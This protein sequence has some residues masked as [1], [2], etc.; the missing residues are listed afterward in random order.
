MYPIILILALSASISHADRITDMFP[1]EE[2]VYRA[3]LG[4]A[5]SWV[6]IQNFANS[7]DNIKYNWHGD[8][9]PYELEYVTKWT[10]EGFE[11]NLDPVKTG[12]TIYFDC[13]K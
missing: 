10:C 8:E 1:Y 2:C 5:G 9:T 6:R 13:M 4:A 11:M 3:R 7:C 12:D